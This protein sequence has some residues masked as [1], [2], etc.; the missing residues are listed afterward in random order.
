M[1]YSCKSIHNFK[2]KKKIMIFLMFQPSF[3]KLEY[4]CI[5]VNSVYIEINR[6]ESFEFCLNYL[7]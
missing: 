2:N 6:H 1:A 5:F 4:T 3:W 7:N